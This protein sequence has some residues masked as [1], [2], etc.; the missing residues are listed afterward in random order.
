MTS[1]MS[2]NKMAMPRFSLNVGLFVIIFI[3]DLYFLKY[4]V[5][6]TVLWER[7]RR[8]ADA[9]GLGLL[10]ITVIVRAAGAASKGDEVSSVPPGKSDQNLM[11]NSFTPSRITGSELVPPVE[12]L[13]VSLILLTIMPLWVPLTKS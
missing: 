11:V 13:S 8:M 6:L 3:A 12:K 7:S 1:I 5:L 9:V 2:E 10:S 4:M